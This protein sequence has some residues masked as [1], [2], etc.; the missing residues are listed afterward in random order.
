MMFALALVGTPP[1]WERR[2]RRDSTQTHRPE[3]GPPT[4]PHPLWEPRLCGSGAPAA[5]GIPQ[6]HR[7][8]GGPPTTPPL[9]ERR[10]RRDWRDKLMDDFMQ[11]CARLAGWRW[12]DEEN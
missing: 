9:W 6:P 1:L 7:P 10:P 5:I 4:P 3:G 11:D 12:N 2:P 8:E